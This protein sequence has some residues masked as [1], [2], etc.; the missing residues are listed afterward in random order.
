MSHNPES[1]YG[2][3]GRR[4]QPPSTD[5]RPRYFPR[6]STTERTGLIS[7]V[8]SVVFFDR[9]MGSLPRTVSRAEVPQHTTVRQGSPS[10][11]VPTGGGGRPRKNS[12]NGVGPIPRQRSP[13]ESEQNGEREEGTQCREDRDHVLHHD[14][15]AGR[16]WIEEVRCTGD[17]SW[18][19]F[20]DGGCLLPRVLCR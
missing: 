3:D 2:V 19:L 6:W 13:H 17:L 12:R 7:R 16:R 8:K 4:V 9:P 1:P 11:I 20:S 5:P 15:P 10:V 18:I 14:H